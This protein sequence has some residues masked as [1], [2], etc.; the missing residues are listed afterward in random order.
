MGKKKQEALTEVIYATEDGRIYFYELE[1]GK[2]TR[3]IID[4]GITFKGAGALDPRVVF[5][6]CCMLAAATGIR[7]MICLAYVISLVTNEIL[8]TNL[9]RAT[10]SQNAAGAHLTLR[11]G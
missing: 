9:G 11:A 3:D 7:L 10:L 4:C 2:A 1:T 8:S 6:C 5:R